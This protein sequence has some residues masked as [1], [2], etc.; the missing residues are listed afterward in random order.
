MLCA[1]FFNS[2]LAATKSRPQSGSRRSMWAT[3]FEAICWPNVPKKFSLFLCLSFSLKEINDSLALVRSL[4]RL[5]TR[6][7]TKPMEIAHTKENKLLRFK[8]I[9]R[10]RRRRSCCRL[11]LALPCIAKRT[12]ARTAESASVQ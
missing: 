10:R 11:A 2:W 6:L 5:F 3:I 12:K 7:R 1:F 8:T 4:V 9:H